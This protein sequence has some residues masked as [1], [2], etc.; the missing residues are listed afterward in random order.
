MK[1]IR[2]HNLAAGVCAMLT[3]F[4]LTGCT[5]QS[6][7]L[8][9][10]AVVRLVWLEK[11][12]EEYRAL[13]MVC[14]FTGDGQQQKVSVQ[15]A[16]DSTVEQ[17]LRQ[18]AGQRG[19]EP[20]F[21]QNRL[22]LLGPQLVAQELPQL[23]EYFAANCGAYRDPALWL[24]YGGEEALSSLQDPMRF[25]RMTEKLTQED[26]LGCTLHVLEGS[27]GNAVLPILQLT[28]GSTEENFGVQAGGLALQQ[29]GRLR[30]YR[31]RDVL[32]G[33]GLL[34]GKQKEQLLTVE[35]AGRLHTVQL[36]ELQRDLFCR[37]GKLCLTVRGACVSTADSAAAD[38]S[39][40]RDAAGLQ[41]RQQCVAAWEAL[42]QNGRTDTFSLE[43]WARQLG[44][45]RE[46]AAAPVLE[47]SLHAE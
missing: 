44:T 39:G 1:N 15:T 27:G 43:W 32:R 33:Y 35:D 7:P 38:L 16:Q 19:G 28:Q 30:Q 40:L 26:P 42:T 6:T 10:R 47:A 45:R 25:V 17:A 34:R 3:V 2:I 41:V 22:L 11:A 8:G 21:A 23:L 9:E 4:F 29:D 14:D 37:D 20:F 12:G 46:S 36:E 24:W 18:A 31:Q 13:T 5:A